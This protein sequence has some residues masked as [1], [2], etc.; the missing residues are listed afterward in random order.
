MYAVIDTATGENSSTR[1]IVY[2]NIRSKLGKSKE[3]L[4]YIQI[5]CLLW[6]T[7]ICNEKRKPFSVVSSSVEYTAYYQHTWIGPMEVLK[8]SIT[9]TISKFVPPQHLH[10]HSRKPE[11]NLSTST[12]S[13]SLKTYTTPYCP[14]SPA[15]VKSIHLTMSCVIIINGKKLLSL[16]PAVRT[17][18]TYKESWTQKTAKIFSRT[19]MYGHEVLTNVRKVLSDTFYY[20]SYCESN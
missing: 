12:H 5:L 13:T 18:R 6:L 20:V 7:K 2:V 3:L 17:W 9:Q 14:T 1:R 10:N 4:Q 11:E 15:L 19:Y 16:K 8:Q